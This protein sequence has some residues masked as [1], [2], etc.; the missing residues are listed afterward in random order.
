VGNAALCSTVSGNAVARTLLAMTLAL[1]TAFPA[2]AAQPCATPNHAEIVSPDGGR[3]APA[4][5]EAVRLDMTMWEIVKLLGP[6][7]SELGSGLMILGWESTDGRVFLVG[8][9]SMCKPPLYAKFA[10]ALP[11][12]KSLERTRGR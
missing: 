1:S 7:K 10:E 2:S 3:L 6:A 8:G 12:N 4:A 5:F 11:S 9:S